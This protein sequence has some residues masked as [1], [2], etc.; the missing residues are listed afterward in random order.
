ME[1]MKLSELSQFLIALCVMV[2]VYSGY[3]L[4]DRCFVLSDRIVQLEKEN[5]ELYT[6][7]NAD[8]LAGDNEK[9]KAFKAHILKKYSVVSKSDS[10]TPEM[11]NR[12]SN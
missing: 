12:S 2:I 9:I 3:M 5:T 10:V 8:L 4:A 6:I 1:K 11:K 7:M